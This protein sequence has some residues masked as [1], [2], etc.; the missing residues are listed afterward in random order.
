MIDDLVSRGADEPYRMFTSRS[1]SRLLLRYDTADRRL[2]ETGRALG[3]VDD[4]QFSSYLARQQ[5]VTAVEEAVRTTK[6]ALGSPAHDRL[7]EAGVRVAESTSLANLCKRPEVT[8]ELLLRL[9]PEEALAGASAE[10]ASVVLNDVKYSGYVESQRVLAD[11]VRASRARAIPDGFDFS[12]VSG[13]SAE[14]V[15]RLSK[16]R[17]ETLAQAGNLPGMTP[18]ALNLLSV[19]I[20]IAARRAVCE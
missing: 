15:E 3:L 12:R 1:E 6:I 2:T 18:A 7:A 11:R 13:L 19:F 20:E 5:R 16:T 17:P 10:E 9:L 14:I 4:A 8:L